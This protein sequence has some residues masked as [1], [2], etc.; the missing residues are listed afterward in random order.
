MVPLSFFFF[1]ISTSATTSGAVR[2]TS[3]A[4]A[5]SYQLR[6]A[7]PRVRRTSWCG[8]SHFL[9]WY[10]KEVREEKKGRR[11]RFVVRGGGALT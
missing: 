1:G 4:G 2:R 9:T 5:R 10:L 7:V 6:V 8:F 3:T 11:S